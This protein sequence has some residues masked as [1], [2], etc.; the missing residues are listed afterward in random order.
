MINLIPNCR[1]GVWQI[2][3]VNSVVYLSFVQE[4]R[5]NQRV[6]IINGKSAASSILY[7]NPIFR[8]GQSVPEYS[9]FQ[10]SLNAIITP[11]TFN[12]GTTKFFSNRDQ[13]YTPGEN[14]QYLK[15]PQSGPFI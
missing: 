5:F 15:F 14:D 7:Y 4:I 2:N 8:V 3:I 13:Y 1:G 6:Q 9:V 10:L 11:T 12:A